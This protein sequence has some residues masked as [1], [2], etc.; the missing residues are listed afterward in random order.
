MR[1][2]TRIPVTLGGSEE[3]IGEAVSIVC[4][5]EKLVASENL[6]KQCFARNRFGAGADQMARYEETVT[7]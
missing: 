5:L 7:F 2:E 6:K 1:R 4:I 3:A